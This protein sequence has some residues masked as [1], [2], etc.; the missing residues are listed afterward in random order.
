VRSSCKIISG[1]YFLCIVTSNDLRDGK[2][3]LERYPS[4]PFKTFPLAQLSTP[5]LTS[6]A[7]FC[8]VIALLVI[9]RK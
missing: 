2:T 5:K 8:T 1:K 7:I 9:L 3:I 6:L 4:N